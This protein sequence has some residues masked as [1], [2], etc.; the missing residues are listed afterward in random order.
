MY[1]TLRGAPKTQE[2]EESRGLRRKVPGAVLALGM[3]SLLTDISSESV[4]A[5]LPLYITAVLG[6]GPLA[7]GFVDGIYQGVSAAV[8]ILGG[9]WADSTR[10][11][12]WVAFVGYFASAVSRVLM[13]FAT[14]F[15]AITAV[16]T[17]DR[18]GKGLR[19]GPR[20]AL[21]ATASD[22]A[23]PGSQLRC[24]PGAGH[25]RCRG[26]A[27]DRLRRAG[28]RAVRTRRVPLRLRLQRRVRGA[29][30]GRAGRRGAGSARQGAGDRVGGRHRRWPFP[31][32]RRGAQAPDRAAAVGPGAPRAASGADRG[33]PARPG[34]RGRRLHLP[35]AVR[36]RF[37]GGDL[38]PAAVRR[39]QR[40]LPRAG[41]PA[42]QAGRPDRQ[43]VSCSSAVTSCCSASTP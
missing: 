30:S 16:I 21:I 28:G 42:R 9:W 20:D 41:H 29:R 43:R 32:R 5:I 23:R 13:L 26:R 34:H 15:G 35:G 36:S 11:P 18:L 39:H 22:P 8:R 14:G 2:S 19:T 7:Y 27:A 4:A 1:V 31:G 17:I 10:R 3:I 6:M 38:L 40:R 37:G 25:R 12:K 24:P 33:R